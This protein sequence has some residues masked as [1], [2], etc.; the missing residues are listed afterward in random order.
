MN[1]E[2]CP[3]AQWCIVPFKTCPNLEEWRVQNGR[4]TM[5]ACV[6]HRDGLQ[7]AM[8]FNSLIAAFFQESLE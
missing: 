5:L 7:V 6:C 2:F 8:D 1:D 4:A 3:Q